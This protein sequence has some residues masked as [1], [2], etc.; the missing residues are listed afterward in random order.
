MYKLDYTAAREAAA[1]RTESVVPVF[2]MK[3]TKEEFRIAR[4][5]LKEDMW[6]LREEG[7]GDQVLVGDYALQYDHEMV[8]NMTD[9]TEPE[10]LD[11]VESDENTDHGGT[12]EQHG[13][14]TTGAA[15]ISG[16]EEDEYE[17]AEEEGKYGRRTDPPACIVSHPWHILDYHLYL[18][19]A[20]GAQTLEA[21][22]DGTYLYD[23]IDCRRLPYEEFVED[24]G[25]MS[26]CF[27]GDQP[28]LL[29]S[30][31]PIADRQ[32]FADRDP[33]FDGRHY[34]LGF[35]YDCKTLYA[36][37]F[38]WFPHD[39]SDIWC[40]W[41]SSSN[42]YA[43]TVPDLMR[44]MDTS[45]GKG[46][47]HVGTGILSS[48]PYCLALE[49]ND[50]PGL[51]IIIATLWCQWLLDFS[52]V[53][54]KSTTG[55]LPEFQQRLGSY[56]ELGRLVLQRA[57]YR[58]WFAVRDG[59]LKNKFKCKTTINQ[60]TND[61]YTFEKSAEDGSLKGQPWTAPG[62][63]TCNHIRHNERMQRKKRVV[64]RLEDL[65]VVPETEATESQEAM[66]QEILAKAQQSTIDCSTIASAD[67]PRTPSPKT[68]Q[69]T[70]TLSERCLSP[71]SPEIVTP[72]TEPWDEFEDAA[73]YHHIPLPVLLERALELVQA[74][75]K[76]DSF[77][78]RGQLGYLL[79]DMGIE[80]QPP[81]LG[82]DGRR[83][84][85]D[86]HLDEDSPTSGLLPR[87]EF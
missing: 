84:K 22:R 71:R 23:G 64:Q 37:H 72:T 34:V 35:D 68:Q 14:I 67:I 9:M 45:L 2:K 42:V 55:S 30:I 78:N 8:E 5:Q 74:H 70:P 49:S 86:V 47:T 54:F 61:L 20:E 52:E 58:A 18:C 66:F 41:D 48:S 31:L 69:D 62:L 25:L 17:M 43:T 39:L 76:L 85:M 24:R 10:M 33:S 1:A 59:H 11:D 21:R 15:D 36:R 73:A 4:K 38:D 40:I 27:P 51:E 6:A 65:F 13:G 29:F 46:E 87:V 82:C 53:L 81:A 28:Q 50:D 56:V 79:A 3:K 60:Y 12:S 63:E 32:H 75:P 19:S 83:W 26:F 57:S 16:A 44:L 77:V 80:I 7:H